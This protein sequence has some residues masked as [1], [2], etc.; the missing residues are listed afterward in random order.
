MHSPFLYHR[1]ELVDESSTIV[2]A[3]DHLYGGNGHVIQCGREEDRREM[4]RAKK[5]YSDTIAVNIA[6]SL[7]NNN[8]VFFG[9]DSAWGFFWGGGTDGGAVSKCGVVFH[10]YPHG[11]RDGCEGSERAPRWREARKES[12]DS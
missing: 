10:S 7:H 6:S 11:K 2:N 1:T 3:L 4:R 9:E 12:T 8:L 5:Q